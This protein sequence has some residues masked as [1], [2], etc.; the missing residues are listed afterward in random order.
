MFDIILNEQT[1]KVEDEVVLNDENVTKL[2]Y[3]F[4]YSTNLH[5]AAGLAANQTSLNGERF[6][7]RAFMMRLGKLPILCVNPKIEKTFGWKLKKDEGCL[8]W[9][10]RRISADRHMS[11]S[12]SYFDINGKQYNKMLRGLPSQIFQHELNHIDGVEEKVI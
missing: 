9:P 1:P 7:I 6:Q 11:I 5:S 12:V 10:G 2:K 4:N 3:F 8:T